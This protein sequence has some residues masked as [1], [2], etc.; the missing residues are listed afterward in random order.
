MERHYADAGYMSDS[1]DQVRGFLYLERRVSFRFSQL[2]RFWG[3]LFIA[4][5]FV[6]VKIAC[7]NKL[8][9][10]AKSANCHFVFIYHKTIRTLIQ[11]V[12]PWHTLSYNRIAWK[13]I[14]MGKDNLDAQILVLFNWKIRKQAMQF[15]LSGWQ[16][17]G[18]LVHL[19]R[20]II[21]KV[22]HHE[23]SFR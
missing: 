23:R 20:F 18:K 8:T 4:V 9:F 3:F 14:C 11:Q 10:F 22:I 7:K 1:V 21:I 17:S 19:K 2:I 13:I 12:F 5:T 15:S 16:K 6:S